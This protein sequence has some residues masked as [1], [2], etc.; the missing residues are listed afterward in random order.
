MK[1]EKD[2]EKALEI[3][4]V[5]PMM[6]SYARIQAEKIARQR[7]SFAIT[8]EIVQE[9][10]KI[11][12]D[13]I[14]EEKTRE[15]EAF[16]LGTGPAPAVEEELFFHEMARGAI[17]DRKPSPGAQKHPFRAPVRCAVR[18]AGCRQDHPCAPR[19]GG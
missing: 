18:A 6:G 15:L 5:P 7:G 2:A 17:A 14:G 8:S 16:Y 19:P 13:F 12:R 11:Y 4:P 10:K 1:W 3:L 9:T